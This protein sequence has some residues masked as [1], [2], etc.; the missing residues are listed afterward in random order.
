MKT[1]L[2]TLICFT[3]LIAEN[4]SVAS[5]GQHWWI[6]VGKDQ[7]VLLSN[8][9]VSGVGTKGGKVVLTVLC[10]KGETPLIGINWFSPF[11][12]DTYVKH[13]F[14]SGLSTLKLWDK[15]A[16]RQTLYC[17]SHID[18]FMENLMNTHQLKASAK[19]SSAEPFRKSAVTAI[20]NLDGFTDAVDPYLGTCGMERQEQ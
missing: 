13:Q 12:S 8:T 2:M 3:L 7:S 4:S 16:D 15:G 20:F 10:K 18:R 17:P 11:R 5:D 1:I 6:E 9:A 14:D 19:P